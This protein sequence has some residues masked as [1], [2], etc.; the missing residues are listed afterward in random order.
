MRKQA[1]Q[2]PF[3]TE[4]SELD[5]VKQFQ[6]IWPID[7]FHS[8]SILIGV[9]GGSDSV[10][11]TRII[12]SLATQPNSVSIAHFNHQ[13][14]GENSDADEAFTER[15]AAECGFRFFCERSN[16]AV[17]LTENQQSNRTSSNQGEGIE[18]L[19]RKDR[20]EFFGRIA[21]QV[22][23]RYLAL[24]HTRDDQVETVLHRIFRGA[25]WR[26]LQGIPTR[27]EL[28]TGITLIRPF[29]KTD[30]ATILAYLE[31]IGQDFRSDESNFSGEFTRNRIRN[32]LIP[33][34]NEIF[35]KDITETVESVAE[36]SRDVADYLSPQI[37][38]QFE[39]HIKITKKESKPT[40]IRVV[41]SA[42][43]ETLILTEV[44]HTAWKQ[45]GWPLQQM[46]RQKWILLCQQIQ[47]EKPNH[48]NLPGNLTSKVV[49]STTTVIRQNE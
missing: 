44:L 43:L 28:E 31:N 23:A 11:L 32:E 34:I 5:I 7:S 48:I 20:Y 26:G 30:K 35:D 1:I 4:Q 27:R 10:A 21:K 37:D 8:V 16:T 38:A 22:G 42:G 45:C 24:A 40:E 46:S 19:A 49:D 17:T 29:L 18:S 33:L 47:S 2:I 9:S 3:P 13:L 41:H 14:R 36:I 6:R 39:R 12:Q 15:L 25:G